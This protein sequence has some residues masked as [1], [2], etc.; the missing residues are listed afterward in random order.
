[1]ARHTPDPLADLDAK[2][3][4]KHAEQARHRQAEAHSARE[5]RRLTHER[6]RVVQ[7]QIGALADQCGLAAYPLDVLGEVFLGIAVLLAKY[8]ETPAQMRAH[9]EVLTGERGED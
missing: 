2:L 8:A 9:L 3:A 6:R 7:A 5:V 1:M 4:A